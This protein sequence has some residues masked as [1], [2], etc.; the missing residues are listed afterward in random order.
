[1]LMSR[2]FVSKVCLGHYIYYDFV[3][4]SCKVSN[5]SLVLASSVA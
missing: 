3:I 4:E 5:F 2:I 1:M